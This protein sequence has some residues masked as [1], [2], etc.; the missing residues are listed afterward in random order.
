MKE[1]L[2]EPTNDD[3]RLARREDNKSPGQDRDDSVPH[4]R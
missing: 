2:L 3:G 1:N 4:H